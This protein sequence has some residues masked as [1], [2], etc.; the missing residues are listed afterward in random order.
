MRAAEK[1]GIGKNEYPP[2]PTSNPI[3]RLRTFGTIK[4]VAGYFR[5][6]YAMTG[7]QGAV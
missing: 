1:N 4:G 5:V 2:T 6:A 3:I 7:Y